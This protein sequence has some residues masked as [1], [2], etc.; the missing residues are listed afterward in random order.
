MLQLGMRST[1]KNCE[2]R[3]CYGHRHPRALQVSAKDNGTNGV[4]PA[5]HRISPF[6]RVLTS[7]GTLVG[8]AVASSHIR[9]D[10]G[11]PSLQSREVCDWLNALVR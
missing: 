8:A 7:I 6:K 3:Q 4:F 9:G 11:W 5:N 1:R 10:D 2:C